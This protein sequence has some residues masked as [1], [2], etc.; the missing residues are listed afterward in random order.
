[1]RSWKVGMLCALAMPGLADAAFAHAHLKSSDPAQ[2]ATVSV[3]PAVFKLQFSEGL[4]LKFSGI[5]VTGPSNGEIKLGPAASGAGGN[6][7][8][9]VPLA[10]T[11]APGKYQ[12]E[13]H[14]LSTD[15]HKTK[16]SYSFTVK[17]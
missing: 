13:W 2:D 5:K 12:V 6:D 17:P 7:V 15:G 11:L 8:L 14:I 10:G 3:A 4:E 9:E 1:M 16:G